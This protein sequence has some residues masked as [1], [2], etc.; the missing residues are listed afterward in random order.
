MLSELNTQSV[1][2]KEEENDDV[3]DEKT[4]CTAFA[5]VWRKMAISIRTPIFSC[6][7][8]A[9]DVIFERLHLPQ[10]FLPFAVFLRLPSFY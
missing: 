8:N 7:F 3:D 2:G 10:L 4:K 1:D 5:P 6:F 9:D